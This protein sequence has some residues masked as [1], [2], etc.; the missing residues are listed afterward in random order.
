MDLRCAAEI[1]WSHPPDRCA[2]NSDTVNDG[3]CKE[4]ITD[5]GG[6]AGGAES[7]NDNGGAGCPGYARVGCGTDTHANADVLDSGGLPP[8]FHSSTLVGGDNTGELLN[9]ER[10]G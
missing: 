2:P 9:C 10:R 5:L 8:E 1:I 3:S 7:N 4:T 6:V